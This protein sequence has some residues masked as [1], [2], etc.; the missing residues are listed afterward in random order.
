[1]KYYWLLI[2]CL[3]LPSLAGAQHIMPIPKEYVVTKYEAITKRYANHSFK[4]HEAEDLLRKS[5][6]NQWIV[7]ADRAGVKSSIGK[8]LGFMEAFYVVAE[9]VDRVQLVKYKGADLHERTWK[10]IG[11]S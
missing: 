6:G 8:S 11:A 4:K 3:S 7:F 9:E 10:L 5:S 1:M 2:L